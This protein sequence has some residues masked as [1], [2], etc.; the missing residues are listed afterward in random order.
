MK[1]PPEAERC[2]VEFREAR[3]GR[4]GIG[5]VCDDLVERRPRH[6]V[7]GPNSMGFVV[8]GW[9]GKVEL[10]LVNAGVG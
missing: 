1:H 8:R 7:G 5:L 9:F 3:I 2:E 6:K 4:N 10:V